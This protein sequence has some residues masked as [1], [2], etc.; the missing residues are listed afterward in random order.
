M[1]ASR[2]VV[3]TGASTGIGAA[4]A[5]HLRKLGFLVFA[6]I[7]RAA[8]GER[9][10]QAAPDGL[11]PLTLDVTDA[12]SIAAAAETV[13]GQVGDAGLT[14][15]VNNAGISVGGV[16]ELVPLEDL[17]AQLEV[18]LIGPVAVTQAFLPLLRRATGRIVNIGSIAGRV[19]SPV[20]GPYA[21]SKSGMRAFSDSLRRELSHFGIRVSLV[22]PGAVATPIWEKSA[23]RAG[24]TF[25]NTAP[26]AME[27]YAP[28][29]G[30]LREA[31]RQSAAGGIPAVEVA[32]VVHH[33][34]TAQKPRAHYLV[35]RDARQVALA[36]WLLPTSAMDRLI[37][38][39]LGW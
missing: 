34:L 1:S 21:M 39:K 33:A 37:R 16:L 22:E 13:A 23:K 30:A 17:R 8:D 6:G 24:R 18:N 20:L 5:H 7:R 4:C 2:A 10:V 31:A 14:G 3:I 15:L 28:L 27:R 11:V 25:R 26:E 35:G 19:A 29:V 9:L 36:D 38:K 12:S 32:Q